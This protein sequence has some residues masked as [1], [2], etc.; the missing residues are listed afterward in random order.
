[1]FTQK[2]KH[3]HK[4]SACMISGVSMHG[5]ESG[6]IVCT[7]SDWL[8]QKSSHHHHPVTTPGTSSCAWRESIINKALRWRKTQRM[9]DQ[10]SSLVCKAEKASLNSSKAEPPAPIV[11][12]CFGQWE[13][14]CEHN[15]GMEHALIFQTVREET[16]RTV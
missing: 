4:N 3:N 1:M 8:P 15:D 10:E 7:C 12:L 9:R 11:L 2:Q 16:L 14:G 13:R 5:E 6:G